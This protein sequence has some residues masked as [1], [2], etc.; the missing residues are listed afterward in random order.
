MARNRGLQK[1]YEIADDHISKTYG[2]KSFTTE[3]ILSIA[4][5]ALKDIDTHKKTPILFKKWS[6]LD[7]AKLK[8]AID[9]I[10]I[11]HKTPWEP[12]LNHQS[13]VHNLALQI[14]R[15]N[16]PPLTVLLEK[17]E[18]LKAVVWEKDLELLRECR[19]LLQHLFIDMV[20]THDLSTL[21]ENES[22]HMEM[23]IGDL[24]SL[25]PFLQPKAGEPLHVP[26]RINNKWQMADYIIEPIQLTPDWMGSPLV[27]YGLKPENTNEHP[28]LL[29]FKGTTFPTDTGFSL[30]LLTDI[31]PGASVGSYAF[32]IGREKIKAWLDCQIN[33]TI[34][35]GKS[36]GGTQAWRCAINYPEKVEKVLAYGAPGFSDRDKDRWHKVKDKPQIHMFYQ[37]GDPVPYFDK[38]STHDGIHH[39]QVYGQTPRKGILAHA[40]IYSTHKDSKITKM[41]TSKVQSTYKRFALTTLRNVCSAILFPP[42]IFFHA[43]VTAGK[44][45]ASLIDTHIIT[46]LRRS[47]S[48]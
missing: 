25:F 24:L 20:T 8:K 35:Y 10:I 22:F 1:A 41:T 7:P 39:Y 33:K 14:I 6:R 21:S 37:K 40:D 27:A 3:Q 42:M 34:I 32:R 44:K 19:E 31:N 2:E 43:S 5:A 38:A 12:K 36:L 17:S 47:P 29:I 15:G 45:C 48:I 16:A 4:R 13:E 11:S 46:H 26:I 30:S 28:P 9:T 23:I 18:I